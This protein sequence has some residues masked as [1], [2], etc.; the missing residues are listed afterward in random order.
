M[1]A[2]PN[3]ICARGLICVGKQG[4]AQICRKLCCGEPGASYGDWRACDPSES[5]IRQIQPAVEQPVGS[6]MFVN[7]DHPGVFACVP[8][9]ECD[10]LD[11]ESCKDNPDGRTVCRIIDPLGRVACRPKQSNESQLGG[12]CSHFDQCGAVQHCAQT[13]DKQGVPQSELTCRRLC[14]PG[15]CGTSA[16]HPGEGVCVHFNRDPPGVG[17]CTPFIDE[18]TCPEV[19]GAVP[20]IPDPDPVE[21]GPG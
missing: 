12:P 14:R 8:V 3:K 17:E 10:V 15:G 1:P 16:C 13:T 9:N 19:D 5:C 20:M 18:K 4:Q 7:I 11:K 2:D 6:G 21:A